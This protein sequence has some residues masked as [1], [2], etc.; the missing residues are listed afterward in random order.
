MKEGKRRRD[1]GAPLPLDR[2]VELYR[3]PR[4]TLSYLVRE[5]LLEIEKEPCASLRPEMVERVR[6]IVSLRRDLG[7]NMAGVEIILRLR[8][9]LLWARSQKP[10]VYGEAWV[11]VSE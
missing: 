8:H 9:Q 7:V 3:I 6:L 2:V 4:Q 10:H 5:G 1:E 11:D